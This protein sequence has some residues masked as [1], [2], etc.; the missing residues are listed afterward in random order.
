[1][2]KDIINP[3]DL[4]NMSLIDKQ[5]FLLNQLTQ[6]ASKQQLT[7]SD[8]QKQCGTNA[9]VVMNKIAEDSG[10]N[11]SQYNSS[12]IYT[13]LQQITFLGINLFSNPREGYIIE[14]NLGNGRFEFEFG[15]EGKGNEILLRN[16]GADVDKQNPIP[17][18]YVVRKGDYFEGIRYEGLQIKAP[19]WEPK[20]LSDRVEKVVYAIKTKSQEIQW[21]VVDRER[22][23]PSLLAQAKQNGADIDYLNKLNQLTV[24][25]IIEKHINDT[26]KKQNFKTKQ[27]YDAP[28]FSPTWRF[29]GIREGFIE[30]KLRNYATSRI[31]KNFSNELIKEVYEK[32]QD[33]ID[34]ND[35]KTF[36]IEGE[37][38]EVIKNNTSQTL[39]EETQYKKDYR[40][41]EE[42]SFE[43]DT[44]VDDYTEAI[45]D[46][47][48]EIGSEQK[49]VEKTDHVEEEPKTIEDE[50]TDL[51][52]M[53]G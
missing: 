48:N 19:V 27:Y 3:R 36:D 14:R 20:Y 51:F 47:D 28:L 10:K 6:S 15:I 37:A 2:S 43:E 32:S 5:T 45:T 35:K 46:E 50:V 21:H 29:A 44:T 31:T 7:L 12:N 42:L 33:Y 41:T 53:F 16:Y 49:H 1:M 34:L 38:V 25:E 24:D 23:K 52:G 17:L 8:Y 11:L 13:V 4:A 30:T 39:L 40:N 9:I 18:S 22:A 26:I